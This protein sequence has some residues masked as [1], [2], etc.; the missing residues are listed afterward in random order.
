MK[1][2]FSKVLCLILAFVFVLSMAG[3]GAA[4]AKDDSAA[5]STQAQAADTAKADVK[6][7]E[8]NSPIELS[9]AYLWG[10]TDPKAPVFKAVF[11]KFQQ[12]NPNVKLKVEEL[13]NEGY[14][15]K[16]NAWVATGT[17]P[18]I[19]LN[20]SDNR[21][22]PFV[23]AKAALDLTQYFNEDKAWKDS[24]LPGALDAVTFD[25]KILGVPNEFYVMPIFY[26][27]DILAKYSI[28]PP[29]TWDEFMTALK[30]IKAKGE[31]IPYQI[32]N[33]E[34]YLGQRI[35]EMLIT[36]AGGRDA[37]INAING[38]GSFKDPKIIAGLQ[39]VQ[40]LCEYGPK[41]ING[42]NYNTGLTTFATGKAAFY[43]HGSWVLGQLD[44]AGGGS[45]VAGK[46]AM[47]P[48]P[49]I[50]PSV[51]NYVATGVAMHWSLSSKI[52]T[53]KIPAAVKLLK[54]MCTEA[55]TKDY[56]EKS[57]GFNGIKA[58]LD[59]AKVGNLAD[60]GKLA[61]ASP[62]MPIIPTFKST[63]LSAKFADG[64][65]AIIDKKTTPEK[66]ADEM[67]KLNK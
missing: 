36:S 16:Q 3:C 32:N 17:L 19:Y 59:P 24:F 4:P 26:N 37:Y 23:D 56:A 67:D 61:E 29:K 40:D 43:S 50:D 51:Q 12:D 20:N 11:D 60:A 7:A 45:N 10:G 6:P 55:V 25:G 48:V 1:S 31:V 13:T 54:A 38:K 62:A 18:D 64:M 41:G 39:K 21:F 34:K 44:N 2:K 14:P 28:N 9:L 49:A 15:D 8:D 35:A 53:K 66:L 63:E 46:Y 65:Q 58:A 57:K 42:L 30:T 52:D 5:V 27:K 22:K 33:D 47:I